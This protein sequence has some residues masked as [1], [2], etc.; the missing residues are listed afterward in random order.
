MAEG[1]ARTLRVG[2]S[3]CLLGER[4]R[5]DG[6]HRRDPFLTDVLAK[7]VEWVPVCPEVELGL[8]VPRAP[9]T[10]VHGG[11]AGVRLIVATTGEDLTQRMR[12]HAAW[13]ARSL[14]PLDLDG[15]ILKSASPSCGLARVR[16]LDETGEPGAD[17]QGFFAAALAEEMPLLA[18][19][20]STRLA[21]RGPRTHFLERLAARARWRAFVKR[22][23]RAGGLST[24]HAAHKY[25]LLARSPEHHTALTHILTKAG[26][27]GPADVVEHYG[28]AFMRAM[29]VP[30]THAR[31]VA[32]LEQLVG[33]FERGLDH[34]ERAELAAAI[35]R[36]RRR[37]VPLATPRDLV[38]EHVTRL[39]VAHLAEQVYLQRDV[40]EL[41]S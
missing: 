9:I 7:H 16:V 18:L 11:G 34:G 30:A 26:R 31:H 8:G 14:G 3:A 1:E 41:Q 4:V 37:D 19:E 39:G 12:A 23:S 33:F 40:T 24:F 27:R 15:Y 29:A 17:G 36:Y 22:G 2:I 6:G 13:R 32:V 28:V 10:L 35:A 25:A 20:D 38:R 5:Y 21:H